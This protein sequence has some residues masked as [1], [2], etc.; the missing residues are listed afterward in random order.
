MHSC[1]LQCLIIGVDGL[2]LTHRH[3]ALGSAS[4]AFRWPERLLCK[5][6][7]AVPTQPCVRQ[8]IE[9]EGEDDWSLDRP[10][11]ACSKGQAILQRL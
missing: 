7:D 2:S 11:A 6:E 9:G 5:F 8:I 10:V 4:Q 3:L 1:I